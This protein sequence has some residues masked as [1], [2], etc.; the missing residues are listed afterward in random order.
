MRLVSI[1]LIKA[2]V[3]QPRRFSLEGGLMLTDLA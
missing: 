3:T 2:R 1:I